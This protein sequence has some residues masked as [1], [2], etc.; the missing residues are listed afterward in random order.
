MSKVFVFGVDCAPPE[1]ILGEWLEELPNIKKLVERGCFAKLNSSIPPLSGVAW[2][3]ITTGMN[4]ADTG[5]FEYVYRKDRSY[6]DIHVISSK[7][8]KQR[9]VWEIAAEQ[10]KKIIACLIP[11]AWPVKPINGVVISG[12]LTPSTDLEYTWPREIK[13]EINNLFEKFIIDG[14][15][16]RDINKN[17][18]IKNEYHITQM[19]FKLMK[20]LLKN[21]DWDLF[22][23]VLSK[24]DA[25]N[26]NFLR[27]VDKSH[28]KYDPNSEF[29]NTM[30][31]YW[32]YVDKELGEMLEMLDE[33]TRVI[34]LSDHGIQR[35]HNRVNLSDWL[36]NE[37]YLVLK[38]EY[39]EQ[40]K[41]EKIKLKM[42][43]V[44]WDKTKAWAIGAYEGQ[45]FINLKGREERGIIEDHEYL[46]LVE[47]LSEKIK[48]IKGDDEKEL[49]TKIFLKERDFR[50]E[51]EEY[52]PDLMIY[53][54]NL[55]YGCNTS[56]IGNKV[57]WSPSTA[58]GSDDTAHSRQGI[59]AMDNKKCRGNLGEVNA[60]DIAPTI[61]KE[62]NLEIPGKLRGKI[63][64]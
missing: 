48:K 59:F 36:I 30:K 43:M 61:L 34:V 55:Y 26:H 28:R 2:T 63:I 47:E 40:R 35:M 62:L 57:L 37:G 3:T 32:Q 15:E 14:E 31:E 29:K 44:D 23:G 38:S 18:V 4:P 41:N 9:R 1:Y 33:D 53:F 21:K 7:N 17:E 10:G 39:S 60:V 5:V 13:N 24:S 20:H 56:L 6:E 49:D 54:D 11:L 51:A 64:S 52:A 42:N 25:V 8:I 19:H 22:F 46:N 45:I 12:T 27:Y 58:K 50:G 16:F